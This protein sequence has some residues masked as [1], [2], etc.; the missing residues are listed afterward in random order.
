MLDVDIRHYDYITD[1]SKQFVSILLANFDNN[2]WRFTD[3]DASFW[4]TIEDE[5]FLQKVD[6]GEYSF[7][8]GDI[9]QICYYKKQSV[10]DGYLTTD[11]VIIKVLDL[12]KASELDKLPI[13]Q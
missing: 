5:N 3:G 12:L 10:R 11:V 9:L 13:C 1:R 2:K 6:A 7:T 8:K 4:A